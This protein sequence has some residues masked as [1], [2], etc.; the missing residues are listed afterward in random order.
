[1]QHLIAYAK[2]EGLSVLEG[3]VLSE[4]VQMLAMCRR[5]GFEVRGKSDDYGVCH[6]TL[7]LAQHQ[8]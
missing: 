2:A 4:N 7:P 6:V 3:D 8:V 5:L 1:M